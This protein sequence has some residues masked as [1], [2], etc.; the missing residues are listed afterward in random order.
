MSPQLL[1]TLLIHCSLLQTCKMQEPKARQAGKLATCTNLPATSTSQS[2]VISKHL[3]ATIHSGS[4]TFLTATFLL[5]EAQRNVMVHK[6]SHVE[7]MRSTLVCGFADR[8]ALAI[9]RI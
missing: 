2:R 1:A 9:T 7:G 4:E 3:T 5:L 8:R 6:N